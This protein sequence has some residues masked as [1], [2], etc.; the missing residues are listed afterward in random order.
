MIV[1]FFFTC[2]SASSFYL[3]AAPPQDSTT[4]SIWWLN[5][6]GGVATQVWQGTI[7][8]DSVIVDRG[9]ERGLATFERGIHDEMLLPLYKHGEA[10]DASFRHGVAGRVPIEAADDIV[11]PL[12]LPANDR[13]TIGGIRTRMLDDDLYQQTSLVS[14]HQDGATVTL[15]ELANITDVTD[16]SYSLWWTSL[17]HLDAE[18]VTTLGGGNSSIG[19]LFAYNTKTGATRRLPI[20]L[21]G[22]AVPNGVQFTALSG[23]NVIVGVATVNHR[24]AAVTLSPTTAQLT[25]VGLLPVDMF[26]VFS[27]AAVGDLVVFLGACG[28]LATPCLATADLHTGTVAPLHVTLPP[29]TKTTL[30]DVNTVV[31]W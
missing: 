4:S 6:S 7:D 27:T 5:S 16:L 2:I 29:S 14:L 26:V 21:D 28:K 17:F 11:F 30:R 12:L 20:T 8:L 18:W 22:A 3:L 15:T 1:F 9:A 25:V 13:H 10:A 23:R 19:H 31:A 24:H